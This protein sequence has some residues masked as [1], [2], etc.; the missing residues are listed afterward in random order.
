MTVR[1]VAAFEQVNAMSPTASDEAQAEER[2][3]PA[4]VA[5][6]RNDGLRGWGTPVND[7]R[8]VASCE[9]VSASERAAGNG[10]RGRGTQ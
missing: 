3:Q 5:G 8:T 9:R 1:T 10:L 6:E 2:P 7:A 4:C